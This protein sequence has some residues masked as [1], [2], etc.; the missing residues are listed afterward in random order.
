[1]AAARAGQRLGAGD[2]ILRETDG[3]GA[4]SGSPG[5]G[6]CG[7]TGLMTGYDDPKKAFAG[8]EEGVHA[9]RAAPAFL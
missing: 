9:S 3:G 4:R 5:S 2:K 1:M 8:S 6:T 7:T